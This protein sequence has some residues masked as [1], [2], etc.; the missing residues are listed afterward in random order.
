MK[1][2]KKLLMIAIAG[3]IFFMI[4]GCSSK[5]SEEDLI[6][7][8][9]RQTEQLEAQEADIS[10]QL[11]QEEPV[12]E[13]EP[14]VNEPVHIET[15]LSSAEQPEDALEEPA[16]QPHEALLI[17]IDPGHQSHGNYDTEPLGPGSAEAKAKVASGTAGTAS[18]LTEYELKRQVSLLLRDELEARGY[19]VQMT[20]E[21]NDVDIS[22][23]ERAQLA[24]E[25]GADAY[26]RI[27]ANA[28]DSSAANGMMAI[29]MTKSNPF[30]ADLYPDSYA[31]SE[32]VLNAAVEATGAKK[33]YIWETDTMTGI[34]WSEVP[35][36]I[37]EMGYMTNPEEDLLL[38]SEAYQE[39]IVQGIA[40]GLDAYFSERKAPAGPLAKLEKS[41]Q[42]ELSRLTSKWDVW[43]EDLTDGTSIHCTQNIEENQPMVSASLIK[44]FIMG[45]VYD[46]IET[47]AVK[48]SDVSEKLEQ[49][50]TVSDNAAAN[51]L[52][53]LLGSGDEEAGRKTVETWAASIGCEN[54]AYH[55]L[56]LAE[57]DLQNHVTARD[58]AEILRQIYKKTCISEAVSEKMLQLL[59]NQQVNDR[60]PLLLPEDVTVAHKTGNLSGICIADV[61]IV[62]L[63][64]SP[65]LI[66]VI[67][68]DPYTDAGATSEIAEL[69]QSVY[70][71]FAG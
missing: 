54:V 28:A 64:D 42:T 9:L 20:R 43:V 41:I 52:T 26:L 32:A 71:A 14:P 34:N 58:C 7:K 16:P 15:V 40:N 56:M 61:G 29:C 2:I 53:M 3:A 27:H 18:G 39:K 66:C 5:Q 49:M 69:S 4:A 17:V 51:S 62:E 10:P 19:R 11:P 30:N 35:V 25:A 36:T 65:Y 67:C 48:E 70:R 6:D 38:A 45:A 50:I 44:L 68:N 13:E 57:N 1:K 24:N 59:E 37:L 8:V 21:S 46:K 22:N 63:K 60:L 12:L 33:E 55:R 47:G 23:A 31:L